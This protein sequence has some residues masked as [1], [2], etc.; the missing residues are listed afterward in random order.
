MSAG[1]CRPGCCGPTLN[2][3]PA[4]MPDAAPVTSREVAADMLPTRCTNLSEQYIWSGGQA[5][6]SR[7]ATRQVAAASMSALP[8]DLRLHT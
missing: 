8:G 6:G 4:A 7:R 2:W 5:N 1:A 3:E